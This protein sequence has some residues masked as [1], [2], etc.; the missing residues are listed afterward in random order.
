M[1]KVF[2][3]LLL[4][5]LLGI[6]VGAIVSVCINYKKQKNEEEKENSKPKQIE[7]KVTRKNNK[8]SVSNKE[9]KLLNKNITNIFYDG[10]TV[11]IKLSDENNATLLKYNVKK[12]ETSLIYEENTE[13]LGNIKRFG[14]NYIINEN[15]YDKYFNKIMDKQSDNERLYPNLKSKL[16][17]YDD[18]IVKLDLETNEEKEIVKNENKTTYDFI[19]IS[20]NSKLVLLKEN[21][22]S[23]SKIAYY[24]NE[25]LKELN[26]EYSPNKTYKLLEDKYLLETEEKEEKEILYKIYDIEKETLILKEK[27]SNKYLFDGTKYLYKDNNNIVLKDYETQEEKIIENINSEVEFFQTTKDNYTLLIK[28][29]DSENIFYIYYL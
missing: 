9:G 4:L 24:S 25:K 15:I 10:N 1:K 28:Y 3:I 8:Y 6:F 18:K 20:D 13:I 29:K 11:Y 19:C 12:E 21:I 23:K 14:K 5:F 26:I 7:Y 2:K 22:D 17:I 16:V 27:T